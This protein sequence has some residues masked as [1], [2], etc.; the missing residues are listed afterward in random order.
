MLLKRLLKTNYIDVKKITSFIIILFLT[1]S[2]YPTKQSEEFALKAMYLKKFINYID[3]P[4]RKINDKSIE[5]FKIGVMGKNRIYDKLK[6]SYSKDKIY[7]KK[8]KVLKIDKLDNIS[9]FNVIFVSEQ[10]NEEISEIIKSSTKN[11]ILL[12]GDTPGYAIAGIHI[13]FN[14][15][16]ERLRFK[17]NTTSLSKSGLSASS[18]LLS[19]AEIIKTK[20]KLK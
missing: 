9:S 15:R 20:G 17:I 2:I 11:N 19:L 8:V 16:N 3:W 12:I 18:F 14:I 7:K 5:Y 6:K 10:N 1:L 13:N 4:E